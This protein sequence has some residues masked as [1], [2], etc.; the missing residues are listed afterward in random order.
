MRL[1]DK[2]QAYVDMYLRCRDKVKA[3]RSAY[4][5]G[6]LKDS[7]IKSRANTVHNNENVRAALDAAMERINQ[8]G[9]VNTNWIMKRL[10]LLADFNINKFVRVDPNRPDAPYCDFSEATDDDWYCIGELTEQ[11]VNRGFGDEQVELSTIKLKGIDKLGA[12]GKLLEYTVPKPKAV[13]KPSGFTFDKKDKPLEVANEIMA[14]V[15]MCEM[16]PDEASMLLTS[17][18]TIQKIEENQEL[19]EKIERLE[20]M[21]GVNV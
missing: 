5:C 18:A 2:Q 6:T 3:Y 7:T 19:K 14:Q 13:I 20:A 8:Q 15:A 17:Y 12:L 21:A 1:T 4:K 11:K 16:S 10:M 9:V